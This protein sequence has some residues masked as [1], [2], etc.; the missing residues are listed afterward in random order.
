MQR[1]KKMPQLASRVHAE[2]WG[3]LLYP[4]MIEGLPDK[5]QKT[6]LGKSQ[7]WRN[8]QQLKLTATSDNGTGQLRLVNFF[9]AQNLLRSLIRRKTSYIHIYIH[10]LVKVQLKRNCRNSK[11]G[12][13]ILC[14]DH[15]HTSQMAGT[16]FYRSV[17]QWKKV[18]GKSVRTGLL[19][20]SSNKDHA[21]QIPSWCQL[22]ESLK[23]G[24]WL[25]LSSSPCIRF[26][27]H[28]Q[29]QSRYSHDHFSLVKS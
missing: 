27:R 14:M 9:V 19:S 5:S 13:A 15:M 11:I 10:N 3:I 12:T 4:R 28:E 22:G 6:Q 21:W 1:H 24:W 23:F 26:L 17:R 16:R 20:T 7:Q 18:H 29:T 8:Y 25:L 2:W